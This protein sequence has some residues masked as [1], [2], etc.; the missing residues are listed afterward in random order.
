MRTAFT[1]CILVLKLFFIDLKYFTQ[2]CFCF[3]RF[4][5]QFR[6]DISSGVGNAF[7]V[8]NFT[9]SMECFLESELTAF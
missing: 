5:L 6:A 3:F 7:A 1:Y 2:K 9:L 4:Y 8:D